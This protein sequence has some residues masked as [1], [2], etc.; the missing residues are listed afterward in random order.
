M[1][2][3]ADMF[4]VSYKLFEMKAKSLFVCILILSYS[5][6]SYSQKESYQAIYQN[7][8]NE[9]VQML[10]GT[11]SLDFK[12]AVFLTENAYHQGTLDY[13]TFSSAITQ[14]S[15]QL[16]A[17]IQQRGLTAYKTAGNW[18]V[19]TYLKESSALNNN[20][21][22]AYDFNDFEGSKDWSNMFV[23]KLMDT[24]SGNCHSLPYFYK[25]LCEELGAKAHLTLAP[26]HI[27][28]KH[29][30]EQDNW[31]NVEL[32]NGGFPR[33][34]WIKG[35]LKV[36]DVAISNGVYMTPLTPKESIALTV[37]DLAYAYKMQHGDDDFYL[38]ILNTALVHY[39]DCIP[40]LMSK[41]NYYAAVGI[42]EKQKASPDQAVLD[43]VELQIRSLRQQ[44]TDLGHEDLPYGPYIEWVKLIAS[45]KK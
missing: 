43:D 33:D 41:A 22:Y 11:A 10:E 2:V 45:E 26:N 39:P 34:E 32:T 4:L 25:I 23:T 36:S 24:K 35:Q 6:L 38:S 1:R 3:R 30:D 9:Q 18:A 8:L 21:V 15:D 16:N 14:I 40:V 7:A 44:V 13:P 27:Y 29:L 5:T 37:F 17:L 42:A 28:I 20:Q 31:A 12:R 19:F